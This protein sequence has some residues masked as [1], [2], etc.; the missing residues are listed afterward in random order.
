MQLRA[1]AARGVWTGDAARPWARAAR[2]SGGRIGALDDHAGGC[3][4]RETLCAP[5][6]WVLPGLIDGHAHLLLGGQSLQQLDLASVKTREEFEA[7]I[8][9][10]HNEI[11]AGTWLEAAGWDESRWG[12][13]KPDHTWL[14]GAGA[15]PSVAWRCDRHVAL[16]NQ[17]ALAYMDTSRDIPGGAIVRDSTGSPTGLFLEQAAWRIVIPAVPPATLETRRAALALAT[18]HLHSL[19]VTTVGAMEYLDDL[20][21]VIATRSAASRSALRIIATILDRGDLLPLDRARALPCDDSLRVRGFKSFAD[22]T[23]GSSTAAILT[24]YED[25][26]GSG[27]LIEHAARG[28]LG[29]WMRQVL[30]AGYSPSVHAIGDRA[31]RAVL[32]AARQEDRNHLVRFEHAQTVDPDSLK[33]FA[34]RLVSMQPFHKATDAALAIN[35]LGNH[36]DNRFFRFRDFLKAGATLGFGSD[37]PISSAD[38]LEGMRT[39]ITG[40]ALDGK[41]YGVSQS[42]T[43]R[44]AIDAYTIGAATCLG[45]AEDVG[46]IAPGYSADFVV[47]DRNPLTCD[48][49]DEA[50]QV[51]ATIVGGEL[52]YDAVGNLNAIWC[53]DQ[54]VKS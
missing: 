53:T 25:G 49:V 51:M 8:T 50:P 39:A 9:Q 47:L 54:T 41:T 22:G 24:P 35:R 31:L 40:I 46:R 32:A 30:D 17:A 20:E 19:G 42:L 1:I 11:P 14:K 4:A 44:E 52:R 10:R 34:G 29:A 18:A 27:E 23:L 43:A 15:R 7:S 16:V 48:W 38:P 3:D 37:W 45:I 5:E 12:G 21:S 26:T 2:F 6:G 28:T 33:D 36:R 13:A